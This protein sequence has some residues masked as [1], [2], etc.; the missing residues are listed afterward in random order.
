MKKSDLK[1]EKRT[2]IILRFFLI[3]AILC[4]IIPDALQFNYISPITLYIIGILCAVLGIMAILK[5]EKIKSH[6]NKN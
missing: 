4:L 5:Y 3:I 6:N 1:K 2:L